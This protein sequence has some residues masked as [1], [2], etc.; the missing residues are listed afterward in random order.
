M[1][2][3]GAYSVYGGQ[4][5]ILPYVASQSLKNSTMFYHMRYGD[6][7]SATLTLGNEYT[8]MLWLL[9]ILGFVFMLTGLNMILSPIRT[10]LG[11]IPIVGQISNFA[12]GLISFVTVLV[13]YSLTLF[14]SIVL[15]SV[16]ALAIASI[17][18]I[19]L[20][21]FISKKL[22]IKKQV[23]QSVAVTPPSPPVIVTSPQIH[24]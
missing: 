14:I 6:K 5:T 8:F 12:L 17:G 10:L 4:S 23:N 22:L 16:I 13:L 20:I 18:V 21:G 11:Y 2:V 15:H 1:T 19:V 3:F 7:V 9:R 24:P